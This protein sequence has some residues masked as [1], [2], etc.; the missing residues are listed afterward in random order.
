MTVRAG[1]RAGSSLAA[2]TMLLAL[3]LSACSSSTGQATAST[4]ASGGQ[5][6]TSTSCHPPPSSGS[7][8]ATPVAGTPSDWNITSFDGTT[9]RA[10]WFP[11]GVA[12]GK[13]APTVLMGPGWSLSGDTDTQGAGVVGGLAIKDLWAA[14]YNV[15]T[16][17]P[18]GFG[19]SGGSAEVD[20]ANFE[21]RDVSALISWVA[22]RPGVQ[23]DAVGDPRMGMVGGSYGGGI[24]LVTA[25]IDCRVDAIVPTIAWHSLVTSLDKADTVKSGW[26]GILSSLSANDHVDPLVFQAQHTGAST[27]M[28]T[29]AQRAWF[30]DRG[31]AAQ[32]ADIKVPTL[33]V[34]G[35]VDTLFTL[36]EGVTNYEILKQRGIPTSMLWF[37]GGHGVCLTPAGD[38]QLPG[39][40][41]IAWLDRYVR[42]APVDTGPGFRFIDQNGTGYSAPNYPLPV[43]VPI[44]AHGHGTLPMVASGGSGPVDAS[45]NAQLLAPLVGPITPARATNA[46]DVAVSVRDRSAVV[47]G[48]PQLR[49]TYHGTTPSG[50]RP[51]RVFAQLVDETTGLV[52][53]NQITPIAVTLDGRSH[54]TTVPLEIVAFTATPSSRLE[55]QLVATTVAY[56]Q[57][58][59][60]G[61]VD[62]TRIH[63][64]LPVASGIAAK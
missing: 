28:I 47:V 31:P 35:T 5:A 60:G 1:R 45:G 41:T 62:F 16:W 7:V 52:L 14:G 33:I 21:G 55:L 38:Q 39:T 10:H 22:T 12:E 15:L 40:A 3:A 50:P 4:R 64:A 27:G 43:G 56:G 34:Q 48:A 42:R 2:M 61:S 6:L 32:V 46:V 18:R 29:E 54:T 19:K 11:V 58:Q 13:T 59:L 49:L 51:T 36:Q 20:S 17:D 44:T 24:Q 25:A 63:L 23:L 30:A 53:G 9:I 26:S 57:P 37:C 8:V